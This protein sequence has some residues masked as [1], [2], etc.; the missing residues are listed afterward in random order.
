MPPWEAGNGKRSR[1]ISV[2]D[3]PTEDSG[4]D[5]AYRLPYPFSACSAGEVSGLKNAPGML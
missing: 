2:G 5:G 4:C 3:V 1:L